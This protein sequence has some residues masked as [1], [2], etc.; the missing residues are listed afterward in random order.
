MTTAARPHVPARAGLRHTARR[1]LL[2]IRNPIEA[3]PAEVHTAPILH[4]RLLHRTLVHVMDPA[5]IQSALAGHAAALDKGETVRRPLT[6]AL[7][8]GLLTAEGAHWR[9]QRQALAP[10]FR[11][12]RV[13]ALLTPMIAAAERA[14]DRLLA[15]RE[16]V[17]IDREMMRATFEVILD[18]MLPGGE[19][20]DAE[21][22]AQGVTDYV[23]QTNWSLVSVML[24]LPEW[25]PHPGKRRAL[26]AVRNMRAQINRHVVARRAGLH[27][28]RTAPDL[29]DQLLAAA[30]PETG[31]AMTDADVTDNLLT[32]L[33]AGHETTAL[34][35]AW[36]L[37]LLAR[38]ALIADRA[39]AEV[40]AITGGRP[41]RPEHVARLNYIRCVVQEGMRLYPP[42][43][44]I[45]R[46][47][48]SGFELGGTA[49]QPGTVLVVPINA[50]HRHA[51][52]WQ[53]PECFDPDRFGPE[54]SEGRHRYAFM[55]FGA[56]PRVCIG[57]GF[58]ML[59]AT[60]ILAV[61]LGALRFTPAL[62]RPPR[63]RMDLTLRPETP[64][65]LSVST[66][67]SSSPGGPPATRSS[68]PHPP[69]GT[70]R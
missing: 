40:Q 24:G 62:H 25:T 17:P 32:F 8:E 63:A 36:T 68:S 64:L 46:T 55:P 54:G 50:V 28:T 33:T 15:A 39:A 47:V 30:D 49:L 51:A 65:L 35:L 10:V 61:L 27:P 4:S 52:L 2:S 19:A 67:P 6:P 37:D 48:R 66:A 70:Y 11:P 7:G 18:T 56:G 12:D 60:A 44:M 53:E 3:L 41:L 57:N 69:P 9:W 13:Q 58:A 5:L 20:F 42:V 34:S 38:H 16:P 1:L 21:Q 26:R 29:L 59:E 22:M 14:R 45:A 23:R 31:R 43:P